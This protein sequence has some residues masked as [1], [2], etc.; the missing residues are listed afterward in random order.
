M[1]GRQNLTAAI[2]SPLDVALSEFAFHALGIKDWRKP[3]PAEPSRNYY[4]QPKG[5]PDVHLAA[6]Q[7]AG[8]VASGQKPAIYGDLEFWRI[9][10]AGIAAARA[11]HSKMRKTERLRTWQVFIRGW[12]SFETDDGFRE[13][14]PTGWEPA[15]EGTG[16]TRSKARY[17]AWLRLSDPLPELQLHQIKVGRV[18][19]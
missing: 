12:E 17:D 2:E 7:A 5:E 13:W 10:P 6:L 14:I 3:W 15:G 18:V 9:T 4:A 19:A 8:F 1:S 16:A 11:L